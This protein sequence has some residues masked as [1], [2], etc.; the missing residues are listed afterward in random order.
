MQV[1]DG[2]NGPFRY[3]LGGDRKAD[4]LATSVLLTAAKD[5]LVRG[6]TYRVRYRAVNQI[7]AGEWSDIAYIRAVMLPH[8]PP[9]PR[10]THFDATSIVLELTGSSYDGDSAGGAAFRYNL[11]SN[12]G[13]DG[14]E[15]QRIA[16][17]D[18]FSLTYTLLAGDPIGAS[19]VVFASGRLYTLKLT[20]ENEVGD[21]E[22]HFPAP[23]TRV[24][25]GSAPNQPG[26]PTIDAAGSSE[27]QIKLDWAA[28]SAT[29]SL[30]TLRYLIY[31]DL[32]ILGS[33]H[34]VYNSS[35]MNVL[36]FSH[37][38]LTPGALYSYWL[39]VEN[40][41]GQSPDLSQNFEA[42]VRRYA[43]SAP[44]YFTSLEVTSKSSEAVTLQ[45]REPG[46]STGCPILGYSVWADDGLRGT[47]SA[48]TLPAQA[49][50]L[51]PT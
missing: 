36:T 32:G 17:Y 7:G 18:G 30:P 47:L 46:K 19:G 43:C 28:P 26:Q 24:A 35:A 13:E 39:Q 38:G 50:M 45:W 33:S 14:T 1:D 31:S 8:A 21:S 5:G 15:F 23:T 2:N 48:V 22:L 27:A 4:S 49:A 10:A 25:M 42:Q 20:A 44:L 34:V 9:S 29:D 41:N 16:S 12:L 6:L 3:V 40:F 11:W 37:S 51:V